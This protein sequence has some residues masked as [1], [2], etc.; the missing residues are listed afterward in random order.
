[1]AEACRMLK[2]RK[3]GSVVE[4]NDFDEEYR[5]KAPQIAFISCYRKFSS[6]S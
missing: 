6:L 1:M 3:E 2:L 4:V 5:K